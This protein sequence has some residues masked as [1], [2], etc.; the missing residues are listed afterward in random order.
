M[1][2][3]VSWLHDLRK[4]RLSEV[5]IRRF[6]A[7]EVDGLLEAWDDGGWPRRPDVNARFA[8]RHEATAL[9]VACGRN[10]SDMAEL[11]ICLGADLDAAAA[12]GRQAEAAGAPNPQARTRAR[13][14]PREVV[15]PPRVTILGVARVAG[16]HAMNT[17]L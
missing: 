6:V 5:E 2:D 12:D 11:L 1:Q 10:Q 4:P 15:A 9:H 16:I 14:K 8:D 17:L 13:R 3:V 7:D